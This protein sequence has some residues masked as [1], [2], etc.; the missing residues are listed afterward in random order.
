MSRARD[1]ADSADKDIS[2]TLNL[3]GLDVGGNITVTGT[4]DGRDVATD[5]TKLDGVEANATA[6]QTGAEIKA[7]YEGEADTNAYTDAEK[8]KL[9]GI[10]TGATAD[11][12]K[13]DID[14]LNIWQRP[15][16][17]ILTLQLL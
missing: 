8:T 17:T 10:E 16:V 4:V 15:L 13:A 7:A 11:Q 14:A 3:D 2:G 6:D 5:G 12:T 9:S 1:L